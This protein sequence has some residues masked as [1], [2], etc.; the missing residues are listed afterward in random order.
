MD[1]TNGIESDETRMAGWPAM[2]GE[3]GAEETTR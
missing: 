1:K 3:E 2:V